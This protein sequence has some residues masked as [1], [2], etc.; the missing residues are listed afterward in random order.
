[1]TELLDRMMEAHR[2]W[3]SPMKGDEIVP[4]Q[5][6][7]PN[8]KAKGNGCC[9]D[10]REFWDEFQRKYEQNRSDNGQLKTDI[11]ISDRTFIGSMTKGNLDEQPND[12]KDTNLSPV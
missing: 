9:Y 2:F 4:I 7:F 3:Q 6:D 11:E 1:M 8:C 12:F 10:A 5:Q